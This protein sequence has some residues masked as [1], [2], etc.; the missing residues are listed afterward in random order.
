MFKESPQAPVLFFLV[1]D[2]GGLGCLLLPL[3]LL[4]LL[5]ERV[6]HSNTYIHTRTRSI[7]QPQYRFRVINR[8]TERRLFKTQVPVAPGVPLP[9]G[10]GCPCP[11]SALGTR[12]GTAQVRRVCIMGKYRGTE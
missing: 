12:D 11:T 9:L 6:P 4:L 5:Y 3:P 2:V 1:S 8:T 7:P 10:A